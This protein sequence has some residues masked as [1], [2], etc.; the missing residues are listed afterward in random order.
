[1]SAQTHAGTR[2]S[3]RWLPFSPWHFVLLPA[4]LILIFPFF[5]MLVTS[6]E[7]PGEALHFPPI[8]TPH[9]IRFANYSDA[10]EAAPF[11]RFFLNS[12]IVAIVTVICNL[13]LCSP[14]RVPA[15]L[16]GCGSSAGPPCSY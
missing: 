2:R 14:R 5:W 16:R 3:W 8:L 7:T 12:A 1:M 11:G 6:L 9:V 4:S 10:W 15:F 13:V